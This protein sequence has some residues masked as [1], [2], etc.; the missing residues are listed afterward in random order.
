MKERVDKLVKLYNETLSKM[1][2][3]NQKITKNDKN[4]GPD[5]N[6]SIVTGYLDLKQE[7]TTFSPQSRKDFTW[8]DNYFNKI[9]LD[10]ICSKK[11]GGFIDL[12]KQI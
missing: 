11:D 2:E 7:N 5:C 6:I 9:N 3:M 1:E 4:C 10:S 12:V 8:K